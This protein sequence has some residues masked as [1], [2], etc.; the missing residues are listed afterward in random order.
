MSRLAYF[1]EKAR[2]ARDLPD[3]MRLA[4]LG[5]WRGRERGLAVV[6]GVFLASLVITT[7]LSYGV[8]LSQIFF[9]ESLKSEPFDAKIEFRKAPNAES[10]GWTNNTSTLTEICDELSQRSEISDCAIILGRQG[11]HGGGFWNEDFVTAQ[12][13]LMKSTSSLDNPYLDNASYEYPE[14][15]SSGPPITNMRG[16]RFLGP[17]A[18]D[19]EIAN[20][21]GGQVIYGMGNWSSSE[22]VSQ[23]RGIYIPSTISSEFEVQVGDRIDSI[24]FQYMVEKKLAIEGGVDDCL[25]ETDIGETGYEFCRIDMMVENMTVMGIYEPWDLGNPTLAPNPIF[26]PMSSLSDSQVRTLIDYDHIY[27]GVTLDRTQL[28]TSSTSEAEDWLEDLGASVDDKNY[29]SENVEL[30][31]F[32]IVGGTITFLNIFL[33]LIQT[34]DYILMIPIVILSLA[35]LIYGLILSLE[36][37]RR[38]VSIHRVIGAN[39]RQLQGMVLLE[40]TVMASVAW[41]AGYFLALAAV[42]VVLSSVGFMV[43]SQSEYSVDPT[44]GFTSTMITA[45]ATLG[46]AIIFGRSRAKEFIELEIDEGVRKV[47]EVA[48]PKVWLHWL[49]FLIGMLAVIDS[50]LEMNGS[51][52]GIVSNFFVEG[53]LGIFG[54][55]LLWIGG[56]LLLGKIGA[57]GPRIMQFFFARSPILSD[58][59]RGLKGSGSAESVNRLAVIMLLTLSIVTLAAVQGYTGTVVDERTASATVGGDLQ[60]T[61]SEPS[62]STEV[63]AMIEEIHGSKLPL[64]A[65]TI[66]T[67]NL[68]SDDGDVMQ[69]WILLNGTDEVLDWFEQS[70]PGEDVDSAINAY[71]GMT[72]SAGEDAAN[73]LD[74]WGSGRRGGDSGDEL[75]ESGD[76]RSEDLTFVW[77]ELEFE[78]VE[79]EGFSLNITDLISNP[80]ILLGLMENYSGMMEIDMS[81]IQLS[82]QNLSQRDLGRTD[83]SNS[84]LSAANLSQ[85]NLSESL[86]INT[87]LVG[88]DL[89]GAQLQNAIIVELGIPTLSGANLSGANLSGAFGQF[90]LSAVGD[91]SGAICPD[92]LPADEEGCRGPAMQPPPLAATLFSS[93]V[94][95]N[96]TTTPHNATLRYIGVHEFIPGIPAETMPSSLIIGETAWRAFVGDEEVD[97]HR[98]NTWIVSVKGVEGDELQALRVNVEA[99]SRVS[100]ASDWS[101]VHESVERNGGLIFGTPGLLSLQF[102]VASI[103]AIASAFVFLSLVLNQRQK[104]LAVLQAIGASPNQIYRLVLFEILSIVMVSM[105]LG[106]ILGIG[107]ALSFN[108]MFEIFGFIFQIFGGSSTVITRDLVWPWTELALVTLAVFISVVIALMIT[109]RKALASDLATV[110][111]GE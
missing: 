25:G 58:V 61:M 54:P 89:S 49:M 6:A 3:N 21:L 12:P 42:P 72:F 55:F 30:F 88:A 90:D 87:N 111:K 95:F 13:L 36:Q 8:G 38:E 105:F 33:G 45:F 73:I 4:V 108:G 48:K 98:A 5:A 62:N 51:E 23:Q 37:R 31:Y 94:Q 96:L 43:F 102:V 86:F 19:G 7:V 32:D 27:L 10:D 104:E 1:K 16:I 2:K 101:S 83:F 18:F 84:D 97:N 76:E 85:T 50:W 57:A 80:E 11:I 64:V 47:R 39:S 24:T 68:V 15:A 70:L 93:G 65:T 26:A 44:L 82:D 60:V 28:P 109:T 71:E 22:E 99:D 53:L 77:E 91:L 107:L 103:A 66:P 17:S 52:D 46:L 110:L 56:A 100:S 34:F 41:L 59:K 69:A 63:M 92:G 35:V 79:S 20:R 78:L 14:L 40:L 29:T 9:Q 106:V 81:E 67:L 74:I 75:L